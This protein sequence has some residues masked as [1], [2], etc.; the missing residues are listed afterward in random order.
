MQFAGPAIQKNPTRIFNCS[1]LP[2]DS[3]DSFSE[4]MFLLLSGVG[5]GYSVQTHHIKKLPD[6]RKPKK[7]RRYLIGDSLEGWADS[8]KIL[9]SSYYD[10]K[11]LPIFDFT[12]I[13]PKGSMLVTSGGKAPGPEPLKECLINIKKILDRKNDGE[14][15]TSLEIHD[16]NCFIADAVLAGGIRRSAMISLFDLDD[17]EML[18]CKSTYDLQPLNNEITETNGLFQFYVEYLGNRHSIVLPADSDNEDDVTWK[19]YLESG[20]KLPWFFVAPHRGRANNTATIL[21]HKIEKDVFLQLW[22]TI[23]DNHTGEPGIFFTNDKNWGLNPCAEISLRLFQ[24]CNLTEINVSD[25]TTQE[26]YNAR[27][28]AAAF[29]GTLQ[30]SYTNFHY[31]RDVWKETTEKEALI[32]VGMTGIASGVVLTL[33]LEEA[34]KVV[35]VENE[36][37]AKLIGINKAART[38]TVKPS[39]TTSLVV[40]SSSGI[41]AWHDKYYLRRV[42]VGKDES[43]Y[44]YLKANHPEILEDD[45]FRPDQQAVITVPQ[46]AP[47]GAILR[48][49]S[50]M[51]L[52]TRVSKVWKEWV[53]AGHRKGDNF[54]NVSTTVT[55]KND[56]WET[57]G[58][59][60]WDNRNNFTALSVFPANEK[61]YIQPP[62][63]T[64]TKK[65]YEEL[66]T[67]LHDI[68]L[69]KVIETENNTNLQGEIACGGT[70][71]GIGGCEVV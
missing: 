25:I 42:R 66:A 40:G 31:L 55:L 27:A 16:I 10:G 49:E 7:S 6:I 18:T 36:R 46:K 12:D 60:M 48:T 70:S 20:Y 21:R 29:I 69:S 23:T 43:I 8:I 17:D 56:E 3:I 5:V 26:E 44:G 28:K 67:I 32:G 52:L 64:I 50:A 33:N 13:R 4:L 47:D 15:L 58:N 2:M 30:A 41:H 57:V 9:M 38:T 35:M 34:A 14:K 37:V 24:F 39:G 62:F 71:T 19:T 63:E 59:W 61:K 11:S 54:N 22:K 53:K 68:D 45:Y 1:F 51:D 65:R